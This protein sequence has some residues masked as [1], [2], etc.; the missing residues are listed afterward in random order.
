MSDT[1]PSQMRA[2]LLRALER[3][4]EAVQ[5]DELGDKQAIPVY[6]EAVALLDDVVQCL[7][8]ESGS[9]TN[10]EE[11]RRTTSIVSTRSNF[12]CHGI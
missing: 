10:R 9:G 5:I 6:G 8:V 7:S 11:L 12:S 4:R 3:A 2:L 1:E